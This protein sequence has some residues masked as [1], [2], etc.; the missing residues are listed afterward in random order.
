MRSVKSFGNIY[1]SA[2]FLIYS[3]YFGRQPLE[4]QRHTLYIKA[5][6]RLFLVV[7]SSMQPYNQL[8]FR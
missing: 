7:I 4:I 8:A 6:F 1:P 2:T 5:L 3:L